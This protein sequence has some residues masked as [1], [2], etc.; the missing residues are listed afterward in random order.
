MIVVGG[1]YQ[2]LFAL[3]V[4]EPGVLP[5]QN[6]PQHGFA[7]TSGL[8]GILLGTVACGILAMVAARGVILGAVLAPAAAAFLAARHFTF[9][10]YYLPSLRRIS[11]H[12]FIPEP[13]IALLVLAAL[14][15]GW[16]TMRNAAL[17]YVLTGGVLI[18]CAMTAVFQ[19]AGH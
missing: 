12:N 3:K 6:P 11:E 14:A 5:G 8:L 17:G 18:L 4:I 10:S 1:V 9:D 15:A 7:L 2:V 16:T 13:W 19:Q